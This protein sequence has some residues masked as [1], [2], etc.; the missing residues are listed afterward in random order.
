VT[1]I[2]SR[3]RRRRNRHRALGAAAA[4]AAI[5]LIVAGGELF[6]ADPEP[7]TDLGAGTGRT[8]LPEPPPAA[9]GTAAPEPAAEVGGAPVTLAVLPP[10]RPWESAF[11]SAMVTGTL[12]MED[13]CVFIRLA[14]GERRLVVWKDGTRLDAS[15]EV[16]VVVAP[17]GTIIGGAGDAIDLVG[18]EAPSDV[19][20]QLDV[21]GLRPSCLTPTVVFTSGLA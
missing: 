5:A 17:D 1:E 14:A 16:P 10:L 13:R 7:A 3:G 2:K 21:V 18:G 19:L 8:S 20:R 4:V 9:P 11:P 6:A 15:G 12:L